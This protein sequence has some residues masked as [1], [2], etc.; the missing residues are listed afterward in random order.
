MSGFGSD[1]IA[2]SRAG[3]YVKLGNNNR[4]RGETHNCHLS[5]KSMLVGSGQWE[6]PDGRYLVSPDTCLILNRGQDYVVTTDAPTP[7]LTFC[8]FFQNGFI[9]QAAA[10]LGL[11]GEIGFYERLQLKPAAIVAPMERVKRIALDGGEVLEGEEAMID[12]ALALIASE[13]SPREQENLSHAKAAVREEV[14]RALNRARDYA[15]ANIGSRVSLDALAA[16]ACMSPFYFHRMHHQAFHETPHEFL[17][18]A[19][20]SRAKRLLRDGYDVMDVAVQL[21]FE[22]LP[23]FIRLFRSRVGQTPG[24][25]RKIG[26]TP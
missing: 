22:S 7:T 1:P 13:T 26:S 20:I 12:L 21:G 15:L 6:T 18:R 19:R 10:S 25:F 5:I 16:V 24:V 17:T 11:R 3:N 8:I 23:T 4:Y 2:I 9:E 14:F